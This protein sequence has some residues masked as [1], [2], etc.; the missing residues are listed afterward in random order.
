MPIFL[1]GNLMDLLTPKQC[2]LFVVDPQEKLMAAIHRA[3][4]VIRNAA[5]MVRC[6]QALSMPILCS[7][8]Y[9]KGLG[10]YVPELA[11]LLAGAPTADKVEFSA[12]ANPGIQKLVAALPASVDTIILVGAETHICIY[13]TALGCRRAGY[14]PWIVADAVSSREK[15]NAKLA[16]LRMQALGFSVGPAEMIIYELLH[17]AGTAAFKAMLPYLK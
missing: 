10:P 3:D 13:Q 16:L 2:C 8:Q 17:K 4:R 5:L 14:H 6:A 9:K 12:M 11:E 15:K 7:T 1:Q